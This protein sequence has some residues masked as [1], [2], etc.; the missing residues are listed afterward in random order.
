MLTCVCVFR[1]QKSFDALTIEPEQTIIRTTSD[2]ALGLYTHLQSINDDLTRHSNAIEQLN[3]RT[4]DFEQRTSHMER[5]IQHAHE[6]LQRITAQVSSLDDVALVRS[7]LKQSVTLKESTDSQLANATQLLR[8]DLAV[9][10]TALERQYG[11]AASKAEHLNGTIQI[12]ISQ[13]NETIEQNRRVRVDVPQATRYVQNLTQTSAYLTALYETMKQQHNVTLI[14]VSVYRNIIDTVNLLDTTSTGLRVNLSNTQEHLYRQQHRIEQLERDKLNQSLS[15]PSDALARSGNSDGERLQRAQNDAINYKVSLVTSDSLLPAYKLR[16]DELKSRADK[17]EPESAHITSE[18]EAK[19]KEFARLQET[20]RSEKPTNSSSSS[21]E[22]IQTK[23]SNIIDTTQFMKRWGSD[24]DQ[25]LGTA[26]VDY[27]NTVKDQVSISQLIADIRRL[28]DESRSIVRSVRVGAQF[29]RT[30]AA[31]LHRPYSTSHTHLSK[32]HSKLALSFRTTEPKGLLAYAGSENDE[33]YMS[34]ILNQDGRV[35]FT[36]DLGQQRPTSIVSPQVLI[37]NQWYDVTGERTGAHGQLTVVDVNGNSI[38]VGNSDAQ[39][40]GQSMLDLSEDNAVL[41]V[42]GVPSEVLLKQEYPSFAGSISNVR[43]DDHTV[44][45]W[46]IR[47][48]T[49]YNEGSIP[50]PIHR[51]ALPGI[52]F[53]GDGY[54]IFS[55]RRL[56]RLEHSFTLTII[57]KTNSPSGLLFANS[58]DDSEKRY[59]AVQIMDSRPEIV[60]DT[61]SGSV[62]L[63]LEGNVHDNQVHRLQIKKQHTELTIQLDDRDPNTLEDRDEESRIENGN[64]DI[65]VGKYPGHESLGGAVTGQGFSG[66]I[67]SILIDRTELSLKSEDFKSSENV[68]STCSMQRILRTVQFNY[69]DPKDPDESFVQVS[70]RNL[71]VPWAITARLRFSQ[72][73]GTLIYMDHENENMNKL[74][75]S[76]EKNRLLMKH[77]DLPELL[78]ERSLSNNSWNYISIYRDAQSYRLY[79]NDTECGKLDIESGSDNY[80]I[81]KSIYIGG[82]PA[83]VAENMSRLVG[84][85]GDVN[86]DGSLIDFSDVLS[87]KNA[88]PKCQSDGLSAASSSTTARRDSLVYPIFEYHSTQPTYQAPVINLSP[89]TLPVPLETS[90]PSIYLNGPQLKL[91]QFTDDENVNNAVWPPIES[92]TS[93]STNPTSA[94][95]D[96]G[97]D[98]EDVETPRQRRAC[99][100]PTVASNDRGRD[101]GYR[102]GDDHR[103]SRAQITVDEPSITRAMNISFHFRTRFAHGLL[104]YSGSDGRLSLQSDAREKE[105][106]MGLF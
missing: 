40:G 1:V 20:I 99:A 80:Q 49:Q 8:D 26:A 61:G 57:F 50:S 4:T 63:R 27:N 41:L 54:V 10:F 7:K 94:K 58:G 45:L 70:E 77:K 16:V 84:C 93:T 38:F 43:L 15:N 21:D 48:S 97:E 60:M 72:P 47:S 19:T 65:Y 6:K 59:F 2:A 29:N 81:Y 100:L 75:V 85:I 33:R 106:P 88:E 87:K 82:V 103:E 36:Y 89:S 55:K 44:S 30:S 78:C 3:N 98:D 64:G 79:L 102:F 13:I 37:D 12:L 62:R 23:F 28:V 90:T 22:S 35:E 66:C 31:N 96:E 25:Q 39:S 67:Q 68:E 24:A 17:L 46:N 95:D 51:E 11:Q 69:L 101:V 71:T 73:S 14:T 52:G 56:R 91:L 86:I 83:S 32:Q 53:K 5:H 92:M 104:F 9:H 18:S 76:I 105:S 74:I 34:L 42:G